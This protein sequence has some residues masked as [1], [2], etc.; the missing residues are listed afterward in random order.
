MKELLLAQAEDLRAQIQR[1]RETVLLLEQRASGLAA[2]V[3]KNRAQMETGI[4]E[5]TP[6]QS[7]LEKIETAI[8]VEAEAGGDDGRS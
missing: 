8:R 4:Q 3:A 5:I 7:Q 1:R 2:E 6:L